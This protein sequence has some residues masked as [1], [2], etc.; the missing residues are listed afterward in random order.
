MRTWKM[1]LAQNKKIEDEES[2]TDYAVSTRDHSVLLGP[3]NFYFGAAM[4]MLAEHVIANID[5]HI[6]FQFT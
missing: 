1:F 6:R 5:S 3:L 4:R 2:T